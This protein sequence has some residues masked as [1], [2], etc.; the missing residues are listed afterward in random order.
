MRRINIRIDNK[1][2]T[3]S[4][5]DVN[6][7]EQYLYDNLGFRMNFSLYKSKKGKKDV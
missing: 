3:E 5:L 6:E 4:F 2:H 7:L 1:I